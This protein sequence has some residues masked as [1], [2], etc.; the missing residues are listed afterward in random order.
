M[1]GMKIPFAIPTLPLV[2]ARI[3]FFNK[4]QRRGGEEKISAERG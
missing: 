1:S 3:E 2:F 4:S